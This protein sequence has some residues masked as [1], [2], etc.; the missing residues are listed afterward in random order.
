MAIDALRQL[1]AT[2]SLGPLSEIVKSP[3]VDSETRNAAIAAIA[4]IDPRSQSESPEVIRWVLGHE[5]GLTL[6]TKVRSGEATFQELLEG[7]KHQESA[8]TV[9]EAW[10]DNRSQVEAALPAVL[11]AIENFKNR[12]TIALLQQVDPALLVDQLRRRADRWH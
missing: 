3:A 2:E 11:G 9:A 12:E 4:E 5:R 10:S 8:V 6:A 1:G 7:L